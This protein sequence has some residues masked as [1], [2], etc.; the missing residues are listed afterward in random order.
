MLS[1]KVINESDLAETLEYFAEKYGST[2]FEELE[3][4]SK[5]LLESAREDEEIAISYYSGTVL[6]RVLDMGRYSFLFPYEIE[7]GADVLGALN[8]IAEYAIAQ[9][10]DVAFSDVP[11]DAIGLFSTFRHF[12]V[13]A[14]DSEGMT[15]RVRV[16]TECQLID[17]IPEIG[18]GRVK[19]N[20]LTKDDIPDYARLSKDENVNKYWGYDY[21]EDVELPSDEYFYDIAMRDFNRGICL[22]LAIRYDGE[23]VG[24][25]ILYSF[26]GRG[27]AEFAIRLLP[28]HFGKG[29]SKC[30]LP[31]VFD[32]A[33]RIGLVELLAR[34]D[35]ENEISRA[36]VSRFMDEIREEKGR[37]YYTCKL[38]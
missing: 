37:V 10:I 17:K 29:I 23:F 2:V 18:A 31:L 14:E 32:L 7:D 20:A 16:K 26:D 5:E 6:I 4:I 27:G 33:R 15:F 9:E 1:F 21:K 11:A 28:E 30:T 22:S 35:S 19:L 34:V 13:D 8:K 25:V 3:E 36:L 24:E 38:Y 12:D